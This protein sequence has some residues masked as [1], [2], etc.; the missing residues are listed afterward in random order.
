MK[1]ETTQATKI[2]KSI[3]KSDMFKPSLD[4]R[5]LEIKDMNAD[6][7][8]FMDSVINKTHGSVVLYGPPGMGKTH[9]VITALDRHN[10]QENQD[11]IV[12]RSH[13]TPLSLYTT[14]YKYR[15]KDKFVVLDDCDGILQNETGL[16]ILKAATDPKFRDVGWNSSAT[17]AL[18]IPTKFHFSGTIIITT[19]V[20]LATGKSR[21]ANHWDA[22]R[23]RCAP[24]AL[25]LDNREEQFAQV[26]WMLTN[27]DYLKHLTADEKAE[28]LLFFLDNLDRPRRIDLRLPEIISKEMLSGKQGWQSRSRR[29]LNSV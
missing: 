9:G 29:I 23:S 20:A 2:L 6:F 22:I 16:N 13:A 28:L 15:G 3:R 25:T 10:K 18:G 17:M 12:L 24:F 26:Y 14:L 19:N 7:T 8:E 1:T 27:T 21:L 5:M 4:L 11:Y